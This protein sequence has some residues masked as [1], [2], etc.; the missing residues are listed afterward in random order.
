[1]SG[2]LVRQMSH[3]RFEHSIEKSQLP[4]AYI[5]A[6]DDCSGDTLKIELEEGKQATEMDFWTLLGKFW[7]D[8]GTS[9]KVSNGF[10]LTLWQHPDKTGLD[11][12]FNGLDTCQKINGNLY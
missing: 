12:V 3:I 5:F 1:M 7:N 4:T 9:V 11:E 10:T 2:N 6:N 8:K